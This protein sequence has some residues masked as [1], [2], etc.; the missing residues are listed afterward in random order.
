MRKIKTIIA[1]S[2][3]F[4]FSACSQKAAD[5]IQNGQE[6]VS[7]TIPP[8]ITEDKTVETAENTIS[9]RISPIPESAVK[10]TTAL[11]KIDKNKSLKKESNGAF[12]IYGET[13][14]NCSSINVQAGNVEAGLFD[15]YNL[16]EYKYGNTSFR[17]GIREDWNNLAAGTNTY[18]VI[19]YCDNSQVI[20]EQM[21]LNY[22]P[23]KKTSEIAEYISPAIDK[24]PK[25]INSTTNDIFDAIDYLYLNEADLIVECDDKYVYLGKIAGKYDSD[26]IFDKYGDYGSKYSD[27]SIWDKY[28]D[29]GSKYEN[30]SPFSQYASNPPMIVIGDNIVGYLSKNKYAGTT[31]IDPNELLLFAYKKF[32]DDHWLDLMQD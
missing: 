1:L 11:L 31:V 17:Y 2:V 3:L 15:D 10:Q 13:S 25:P 30:C 26:S 21:E 19:A 18:T 8:A 14:E 9:E 7:D 6:K 23:P 29:Y 27:K 20:E 22:A 4:L 16:K 28:G 12:Y 5:I 32:D 24:V